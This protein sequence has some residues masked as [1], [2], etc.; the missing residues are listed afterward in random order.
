MATP[1]PAVPTASL[2]IRGGENNV[3]RGNFIGT[4]TDGTALRGPGAGFA[5]L[6]GNNYTIEDNVISCGNAAGGLT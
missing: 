3:I 2:G 1:S 5:E 6:E 4:N